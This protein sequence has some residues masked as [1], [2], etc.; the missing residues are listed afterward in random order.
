VTPK[1]LDDLDPFKPLSAK[2]RRPTYS[3]GGNEMSAGKAKSGEAAA[4]KA[5]I[6]RK[7]KYDKKQRNK[8]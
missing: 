8:T 1:Q 5:A 3:I 7:I 6:A 4:L 2:T